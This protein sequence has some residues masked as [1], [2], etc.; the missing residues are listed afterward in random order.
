MHLAFTY[1]GVQMNIY[2]NGAVIGTFAWSGRV[3]QNSA[4]QATIG[5]NPVDDRY[6]DGVLDE[7]R[8]SRVA[9]TPAWLAT[10]HLNQRA[11]ASFYTVGWEE[12]GP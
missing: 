1:N 3:A 9:R 7:V 8:L 6:F 11:P 4:V 5:D 12:Q 2:R 10:Q